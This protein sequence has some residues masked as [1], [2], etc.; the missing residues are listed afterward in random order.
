MNQPPVVLLRQQPWAGQL[1]ILWLSEVL[2]NFCHSVIEH[3]LV[4][5]AWDVPF[6]VSHSLASEI[7]YCLIHSAQ[8]VALF[9]VPGS[10]GVVF[11]YLL[12]VAPG[13]GCICGYRRVVGRA[14]LLSVP[15]L[16]VVDDSCPLSINP[17]SH[18]SCL[19]LQQLGACSLST[20][21]VLL[22]LLRNI[23]PADQTSALTEAAYLMLSRLPD[24]FPASACTARVVCH[25]ALSP[26][27]QQFL[28]RCIAAPLL[29]LLL[30][31][32][33]H[34][35]CT[36]SG[37]EYLSTLVRIHLQCARLGF[38]AWVGKIPWRRERL[39]HSSILAWR[40]P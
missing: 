20:S 1:P 12:K 35:S 39:P 2:I 9:H 6:K 40:V 4:L 36:T 13:Y 34:C 37:L 22:L 31:F 18:S 8:D 3:T 27:A 14:V 17:G 25:G 10:S 19:S 5:E 7:S 24:P 16:G 32:V 28:G 26:W 23:F 29:L 15:A 30:P 11:S 33:S 38:D 21:Y